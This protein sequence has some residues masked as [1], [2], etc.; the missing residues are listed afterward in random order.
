VVA[1]SPNKKQAQ[2]P[3]SKD[4]GNKTA[5]LNRSNDELAAHRL[6]IFL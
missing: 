2:V 5:P 3:R 4:A 1:Q 6:L